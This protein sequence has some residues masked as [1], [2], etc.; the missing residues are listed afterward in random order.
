MRPH[1]LLS[2]EGESR[3]NSFQTV[4]RLWHGGIQTSWWVHWLQQSL[5]NPPCSRCS[6][7]FGTTGLSR[8]QDLLKTS[9]HLFP[10]RGLMPWMQSSSH[11]NCTYSHLPTALLET[12]CLAPHLSPHKHKWQTKRQDKVSKWRTNG[13][14][15]I[16][17]PLASCLSRLPLQQLIS[18][19]LYKHTSLLK[20]SMRLRAKSCFG[21]QQTA[22][23]F[24]PPSRNSP[25]EPTPWA[26]LGPL[27]VLHT[28]AP[29]THQHFE[30]CR[31]ILR[32][33]SA[34]QY[35]PL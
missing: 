17:C 32:D 18:A 22:T 14:F 5:Q 20:H 3:M 12:P 30:G 19:F 13:H 29:G 1:Q 16:C 24:H 10:T 2:E 23:I 25:R 33:I 34:L 35:F 27:A 4:I 26:A 7:Q 28:P 9:K 8:P 6:A 21:S 11:M 31:A 15:N